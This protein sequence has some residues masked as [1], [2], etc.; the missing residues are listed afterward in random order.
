MPLIQGPRFGDSAVP[1][2]LFIEAMAATSEISLITDA[3]QDILYVSDSFTAITGYRREEI[4]GKNCRLLQGP[5]TDPETRLE[6]RRS[7]LSGQPFQGEIL[8]Y[9]KDGSAFW[10]ALR[11][12]P[13]RSGT[14]EVSH[15][16]S[17]QRDIST[18][19]ALLEQLRVQALHDDLTGLPNRAAINEL[20]TQLFAESQQA[21]I[22]AAVGVIDLDDFR[23]A[24]NTL[25]HAAGD[26]VLREWAVRMQSA[27]N[28]GDFLGRMGGDEFLLVLRKV[29]R[30]RSL[31]DLQVT[32]DRL[33]ATVTRPFSSDGV[34]T[35]IGMSMGL[36]LVPE[37]GTDAA[38][39]LRHADEALY[40]VKSRKAGRNLW[41]QLS[42]GS[43]P[44]AS[45]SD[46]SDGSVDGSG[47]GSASPSGGTAGTA[48]PDSD[49]DTGTGRAGSGATAGP[50]SS[51]DAGSPAGFAAGFAAAEQAAPAAVAEPV[52]QPATRA[53]GGPRTLAMAGR[54]RSALRDGG[55][56]V[57]GQPVIDLVNGRVQFFEA[58]ARLQLP[59]GRLVAP[60]E[61]LP[62]FDAADLDELFVQ[63][64]DTGLGQLRDW[65]ERGDSFNISINLAPSTLLDPG[66]PNR[67]VQALDRH[68]V[69]PDRLSFELLETQSVDWD[70]QRRALDQ[71][72]ELGV[73]LAMDDL[74]AGYSSLKRLSSLPFSALKVDRGLL[75]DIRRK[76]AETLSLIATLIQMG[77]DF[78]MK[79]VVE[80][81]EDDGMAEAVTVLGAGL[82]QGYHF[83]RPLPLERAAEW[84]RTFRMDINRGN[85][86]T[87][88]GALA[89]HWR[90]ARLGSPHPLTLPGCPLTAFLQQQDAPGDVAR[91]HAQHHEGQVAPAGSGR[92]LV[93]WLAERV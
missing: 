58:L 56:R 10:N 5:G 3:R 6:I 71:L 93:D 26:R 14:D 16:V 52:A 78:G 9:R 25:G 1:D 19:M 7:L 57:H 46:A 23:I 32:L 65:D 68:G 91:W 81:L 2:D 77:R 89:Y 69:A 35:F 4:L 48:G 18:R 92:L 61:F 63:V 21:D 86:R 40:E 67:I 90:F 66:T 84:A 76:P 43:T 53:P 49:P 36:A 70:I 30:R 24:N 34:D 60:A 54:Y 11:I 59:D 72:V 62:H 13:L 37:D 27:L 45:P 80:G 50:A 87:Y 41:W 47:S 75:S 8:N 82:G 55:L 51:P 42:P 22:T 17:V 28:E 88:L 12:S 39:L 20:L 44:A 33:H 83:S 85:F 79:V 31:K 73:D 64:L 29:R 15:F 38:T 74:G